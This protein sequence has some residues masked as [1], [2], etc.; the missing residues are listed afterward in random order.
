MA[1]R[2]K[3]LDIDGYTGGLTDEVTPWAGVGLFL[4]LY[5]RVGVGSAVEQGLPLKKSPKGLRHGEMVEAFVLLSAL[6]GECLDDFGHLRPDEG[7]RALLGYRL[8][9]P[10]T[11]RQWLDKAHEDALVVAAQETAQQQRFLSAIP[12]ESTYL[13][14]L[15]EGN[16]RVL[17]AY[18]EAQTPGLLVTLDVDAHLVETSKRAALRTYEGYRGY[19]PLL[20]AWAETGLVLRDEFRDGNVPA[21]KDIERVV[22]EAVALLPPRPDGAAWQVQVRSDAAA[23]TSGCWT[24]GPAGAGRSR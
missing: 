20:V 22:D 3:Y 24:T 17:A 11:A 5:R 10:P 9:A 23:T 19:Q 4:E 21:G 6:G 1:I 16:R 18:V 15:Q 2:R 14:G 7:L 8:P 13:R 12:A